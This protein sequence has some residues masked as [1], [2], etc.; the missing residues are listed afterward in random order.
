MFQ[1]L[2][3]IAR[4]VSFHTHP[5]SKHHPY[6]TEPC[7][8]HVHHKGR[9][10][11]PG[12]LFHL[13]TQTLRYDQLLHDQTPQKSKVCQ[14]HLVWCPLLLHQLTPVFDEPKYQRVQSKHYLK[15]TWI[16]LDILSLA[17]VNNV[18]IP[19]RAGTPMRDK[20][21]TV[22]CIIDGIK[23]FPRFWRN[24]QCFVF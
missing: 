19:V 6:P 4:L 20:T 1:L 2:D 22:A 21:P 7:K 23:S 11:D 24:H 10:K 15:F 13:K 3:Y 8:I 16:G 14:H 17:Y 9:D 12:L 5:R 18:I